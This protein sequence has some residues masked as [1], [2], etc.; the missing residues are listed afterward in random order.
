MDLDFNSCPYKKRE[1]QRVTVGR[2]HIK[3]RGQGAE[4]GVTQPS[5]GTPGA[6]RNW[7][8]RKEPPLLSK[9]AHPADTLFYFTLFYFLI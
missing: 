2:R 4:L 9:G 6:T 7:E 3:T 8:G 5:Q 1:R